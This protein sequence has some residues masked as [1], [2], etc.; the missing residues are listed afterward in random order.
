MTIFATHEPVEFL[1]REHLCTDLEKVLDVINDAKT[2]TH[3]DVAER[4][5][6]NLGKK[7]KLNTKSFVN[8]VYQAVWERMFSK[9][10]EL[11]VQDI[12]C[13]QNIREINT[14]EI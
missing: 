10:N 4:M 7:W 12:E 1:S 13:A 2:P 14:L 5:L 3:L 8:P 9:R 6:Q 11:I